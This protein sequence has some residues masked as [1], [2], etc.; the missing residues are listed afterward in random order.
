[1]PIVAVQADFDALP[2]SKGQFDLLVFDASLHYAPDPRRTLLDASRMLAMGGALAVMDSPMFDSDR[3]GLMMA[4]AQI[5]RIRQQYGLAEPIRPGKGYLTFDAL[6]ATAA[7][8]GMRGRFFSSQGTLGWR[9]R[10]SVSRLRLGRA[11]AS[12]GAWIAR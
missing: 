8:A 9:A 7:D 11:P 2:F 1:V 3:D 6:D 10:R 4:D 5:G 12:F